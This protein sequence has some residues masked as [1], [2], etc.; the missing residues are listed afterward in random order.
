[1]ED[2]KEITYSEYVLLIKIYLIRKKL[3]YFTLSEL[4]R[5]VGTPF[6]NPIMQNVKEICV[7][8]NILNL[9]RIEGRN[10]IY[11]LNAKNLSNLIR[12]SY[13]FNIT[14]NF[15]KANKPID[16]NF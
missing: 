8:K 9:E 13:I 16:Y 2:K 3:K 10:H 15:I 6:S 7:D 1:M 11:K 12:S 5:M 4:G 14:G